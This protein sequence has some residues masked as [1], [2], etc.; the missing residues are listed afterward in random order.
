MVVLGSGEN[1]GTSE[2][3][4]HRASDYNRLNSVGFSREM[5]GEK[6]SCGKTNLQRRYGVL[7]SDSEMEQMSEKD[8]EMEWGTDGCAQEQKTENV[9]VGVDE[10]RLG[11]PCQK[12]EKERISR[13]RTLGIKSK[14]SRSSSLSSSAS[15]RSG[16]VSSSSTFRSGSVSSSDSSWSSSACSSSSSRSSSTSSSGSSRSISVSSSGSS[17]SSSVSSS[18]SSRSGSVSSSERYGSS[19]DDISLASRGRYAS[20]KRSCRRSRRTYSRSRSRS[21]S[22][23][24]YQ[25][26]RCRMS[27]QSPSRYR[28][29]TRCYMPP[30]RSYRRSRS[31]LR[32]RRSRSRSWSRSPS[33]LQRSHNGFMCRTQPPSHR[34]SRSRSRDRSIHLTQKEK[35]K[36]LEIAKANA[37]KLLGKDNIHLLPSLKPASPL[38]NERLFE[39]KTNSDA[40]KDLTRKKP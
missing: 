37:D 16:S 25:R 26:S 20:L 19:S 40:I 36:L 6:S 22:R 15:S 23:S 7:K 11:S 31:S 34:R 30:S 14:I 35:K 13:S 12:T 2:S 1:C 29:R 21:W 9:G 27:Y 8:I 4:K 24:C 33:R 3:P 5:M 18:G 32:Y 10:L 17:R 28:S 39:M 38:K